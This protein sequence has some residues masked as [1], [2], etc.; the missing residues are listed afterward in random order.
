M[1]TALGSCVKWPSMSRSHLELGDAIIGYCISH[2]LPTKVKL[3]E[4]YRTLISL[5]GKQ[6]HFNSKKDIALCNSK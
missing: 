2:F 5:L 4:H 3:F 6:H 1:V